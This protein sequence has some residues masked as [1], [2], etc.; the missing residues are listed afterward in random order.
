ME[1][2]YNK[3]VRDRIPEI[4]KNNGEEP[5]IEI[6]NDK[7]YK[8]ELEKKLYEE[9]LEVIESSGE[10]RLEELADMISVIASLAKLEKKDLSDII[11]ISTKKDEKRGS[12]DKKIYLKKVLINK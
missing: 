7:E 4:I 10:S 9:Y 2:I 8:N 6:L 3:L 11:N 5:I 1:Q 12:F